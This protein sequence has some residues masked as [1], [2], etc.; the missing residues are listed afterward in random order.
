MP[1]FFFHV[2]SPDDFVRD[3]EGV[4]L[5]DLDRAKFEAREGAKGLLAE[6]IEGDRVLDHQ[7]FEVADETGLI[8]FV[9]PFRDAIKQP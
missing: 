6:A 5:P 2:R 8:L 4:D 1:R 7:R 9:Y 3:E